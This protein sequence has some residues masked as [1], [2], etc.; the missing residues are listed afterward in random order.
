MTMTATE[1]K[2]EL[3]NLDWM[4][5][6]ETVDAYVSVCAQIRALEEQKKA[7]QERMDFFGEKVLQGTLNRVTIV[8]MPGS[9]SVD[10]KGMVA[11]GEV[12]QSV[13]DSYTRA[14]TPFKQYRVS[15]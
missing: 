3:S 2:I 10:V 14:G 4:T 11:A 9:K 1:T 15:V 12:A 8:Q 6:D 7:L 13:V 5:I